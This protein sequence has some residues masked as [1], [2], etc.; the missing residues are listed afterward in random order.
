ML[1]TRRAAPPPRCSVAQKQVAFLISDCSWLA[2]PIHDPY[3]PLASISRT[4]YRAAGIYAK[5]TPGRG[6]GR[7]RGLLQGSTCGTSIDQYSVVGMGYNSNTGFPLT[8][9][10]SGTPRCGSGGY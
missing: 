8:W 7:G 3:Q 6:G 4:A 2:L 1:L 10:T 5:G 9:G